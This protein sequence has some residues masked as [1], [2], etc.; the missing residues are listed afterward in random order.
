MGF[1]PTKPQFVDTFK[2]FFRMKNGFPPFSDYKTG[3]SISAIAQS[4]RRR[5]GKAARIPL[6]RA[7]WIRAWRLLFPTFAT[8]ET[9][10]RDT[11]RKP[12]VRRASKG[13]AASIYPRRAQ[14]AGDTDTALACGIPGKRKARAGRS[15]YESVK[16]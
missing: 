15:H 11:R 1:R 10:A 9:P 13:G 5:Q 6:C 16:R 7:R 14:P 12:S 2:R 8:S 3:A 4:R